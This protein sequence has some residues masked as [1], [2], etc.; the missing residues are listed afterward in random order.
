MKVL[1]QRVS[2]ARVR[3]DGA[4]V[5]EIER[6]LLLLVGFAKE[7]DDSKLKPITQKLCNL[8]IFPDEVGRFHLSVLDIEGE[9]LLVPQFTLY[10]DTSKGRRPE[11]FSAMEPQRATVMFD[12]LV[13]E[14]KALGVKKVQTGEFGAH[15][16]VEL[17]NDGPVTIMVEI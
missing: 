1:L 12:A 6:G 5:G 13:G 8:R 11:F 2:H 15:M 9:V 3:V 14:F 16:H 7:D 17:E 10:A 4:S